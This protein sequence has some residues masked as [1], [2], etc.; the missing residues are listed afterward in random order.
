MVAWDARGGRLGRGGGFYDRLFAE[1]TNGVTRVGLAYEFQECP[2]IPCEPW[3]VCLD[4]VITERRVVGC[5][6]AVDE[7]SPEKG[8]L[9][10]S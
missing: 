7:A 10:W 3:D 8:G 4:Y 1:L 6:G 9:Q 2:E 5:G